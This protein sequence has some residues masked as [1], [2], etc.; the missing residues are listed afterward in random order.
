MSNIKYI[1]INSEVIQAFQYI[2]KPFLLEMSNTYI[3]LRGRSC[4][5]LFS[6][7]AD[8]LGQGEVQQKHF[9][10]KSKLEPPNK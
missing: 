7:S 4:L 10:Y 6:K 3:Y 8:Y 9:N 2:H 5:E 1:Q